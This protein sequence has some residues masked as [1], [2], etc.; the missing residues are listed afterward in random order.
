MVFSGIYSWYIWYF[1][2][3]LMRNFSSSK[4]SKYGFFFIFL[5]ALFH[6]IDATKNETQFSCQEPQQKRK[7]RSK[8]VAKWAIHLWYSVNSNTSK[9]LVLKCIQQLVKFSNSVQYRE[10]VNIGALPIDS[11]YEDSLFW[12]LSTRVY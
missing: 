3:F 9:R 11:I 12:R 5:I 6:K 10:R 2:Y 4:I 1:I 8:W 7:I